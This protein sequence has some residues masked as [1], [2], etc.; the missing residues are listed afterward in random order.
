MGWKKRILRI[1]SREIRL[2][3]RLAM[4]PLANFSRA[5]AISTRGVSTGTPTA[6]MPIHLAAHELEDQPEIVNHQIEHHVDVEAALGKR[7]QPVHFDE[8]RLVDVRPRGQHRRIEMLDVANGQ[9]HS[10]RLGRLQA[11]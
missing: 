2:A 11:A 4:Q 8:A 5:L 6:S 10:R 3:V 7:P 1:C 9:H